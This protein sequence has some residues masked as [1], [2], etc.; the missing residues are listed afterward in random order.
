[1]NK[2]TDTKRFR[3]AIEGMAAVFRQEP[4]Q[5]LFHGF[6][7]GL[8]ALPIETVE[9]AVTRGI[10]ECK[11]MPNPAELR[12]FAGVPSAA[13][14]ALLAWL[15]FEQAVVSHGGYATVD[16]EDRAINATVRHLG[17]WNRCCSMPTEEFDKWLK[18]E[19]L[20]TYP[21]MTKSKGGPSGDSLGGLHD[22]SNS[23]MG[24]EHKREIIRVPSVKPDLLRLEQ[25]DEPKQI[26][27]DFD[28][29]KN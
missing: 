8:K 13:D 21:T 22:I 9:A 24:I 12:E 19:F 23:A 25:T 27:Q 2:K 7:E 18:K 26:Q 29:G 15:T 10:M 4:T 3:I 14:A 5:A 17:G 28:R 16:F 6:W 1:M 20:A 11:F